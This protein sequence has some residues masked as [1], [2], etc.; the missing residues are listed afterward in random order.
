MSHP[1][2]AIEGFYDH[3]Q[4]PARTRERQAPDWGGDD[5]FTS[6]PRR[7]RFDHARSRQR[8]T[9]E[10]PLPRRTSGAATRERPATGISRLDLGTLSD[11]MAPVEEPAATPVEPAPAPV[12]P[13]AEAAL[14][15]PAPADHAEPAPPA[16]TEEPPPAG[17][18]TVTIT[19]HPGDSP[20]R[21]RPAPSL[22]ERLVGSRPER[23]AAYA[24]GMGLLLILIA[25][26]TAG[27]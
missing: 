8:D 6:T 26:L 18:R 15:D 9:G 3:E 21:R 5:L 27:S 19:G 2:S 1:E 20:A 17:R 14:V 13:P 11:L 24:F 4:E 12:A 7:R 22:D 25:I 10:H 23:I 16:R